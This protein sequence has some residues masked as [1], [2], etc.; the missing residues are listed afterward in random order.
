MSSFA[1]LADRPT[2]W[3]RLPFNPAALIRSDRPARMP[4]DC[5]P[6]RPLPPLNVTRSAPSAM[7]FVRLLVGGSIA[8]ASTSTGTPAS[9]AISQVWASDNAPCP[10]HGD[11]RYMTSAVRSLMAD[12]SW[13]GSAEPPYPTSTIVAPAGRTLW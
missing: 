11:I 4:D 5:G 1:A 12:L 13:Y 6:I 2:L 3:L 10:A 7:N 9:W 8:A